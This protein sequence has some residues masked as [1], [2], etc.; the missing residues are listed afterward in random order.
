MPLLKVALALLLSPV[1]M[2]FF[3]A[4]FAILLAGEMI[5]DRRAKR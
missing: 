3:V 2:L 1:A 5:E 4:L